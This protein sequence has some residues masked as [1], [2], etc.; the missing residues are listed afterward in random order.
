M[1][2]SSNAPQIRA[3]Q[4]RLK[5]S[6]H[7]LLRA[8]ALSTG[9]LLATGAQT[10]LADAP[11]VATDITPVYSLV[12]QVMAGVGTPDLIIQHGASPHDHRMRPSDAAALQDADM[13]VWIGEALTPALGRAL[14]VLASDTVKISLLELPGTFKLEARALAVFEAEEDH[15][16]HKDEHHDE[17][18]HEDHKDK[19][20]DED[21]HDDHKDKHGHD[22]HKDEHHDEHGHD[23]HK[24]EHHDE[25]GHDDHKDKHHDEHGHDNHKNEHHDEEGHD[26]HK[27]EH[28]DEEGHDDHGHHHHDG[29]DPHVWLDPVNAQYWL[30]EIAEALSAIDPEHAAQ[31]QANAKASAAAL[32]TVTSKIEAELM[33]NPP[34]SYI[35]YHDAYQYFEARFGIQADGAIAPSDMQRPSAARLAA[36]NAHLAEQ[37][38]HCIYSEPQY[39]PGLI[40]AL[41]SEGGLSHHVIDPLGSALDVN[42]DFY[43]NLMMSVSA[44]LQDCK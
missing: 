18:G 36:L 26:D 24:D 34:A 43:A 11:R 22:D 23:D 3:Q 35:V 29:D 38:V 5:Q 40:N 17:H 9:L 2:I 32:N 7:K 12:A 10:A 41:K 42:A 39:Q 8:T 16:D 13:V 15:E 14:D 27:D 21:G 37:D 31:Y 25:H 4:H 1:S 44:S 6:A 30:G 28:H 20:H 19:H 33:A